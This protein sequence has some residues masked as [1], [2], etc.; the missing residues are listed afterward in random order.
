MP[1][2]QFQDPELQ[3]VFQRNF[4]CVQDDDVDQRQLC[5]V[6][7]VYDWLRVVE[8]EQ[9]PRVAIVIQTLLSPE[10]RPSLR[11]WYQRC[12]NNMNPAAIAFR[13]RL[14]Q[15]AEENFA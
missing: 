7:A 14:S 12:G 13:A 11:R 15:L 5:G 6:L 1:L 4:E 3:R 2:V 9:S 10:F 8:G